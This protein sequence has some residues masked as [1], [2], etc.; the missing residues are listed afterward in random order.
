MHVT[1]SWAR[2]A[3]LLLAA[4]LVATGC[5]RHKLPSPPPAR[6]VVLIEENHAYSQIRGSSQAPWLNAIANQGTTMTQS[7][8]VTHPSEPNYLALFSGRTQGVSGDPCPPPGA[9]YSTPNLSTALGTVGRTFAGYSEDLPFTGS[10]RCSNGAYARKHNPVA[11]F[12]RVPANRNRPFSLFPTRTF[13]ALPTVSFVVPNLDHDM[14]DGSVAQGDAWAHAHLSG[15]VA[16]AQRH[17]SLLIVTFDEDNDSSGNHILT[18]FVGPMV[19]KGFSSQH[20]THYDLLRTI[21]SL[22]GARPVGNSLYGHAVVGIW[23]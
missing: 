21:E 6:T 19:K 22:Y 11:D 10:L 14:H 12:T 18:F 4:G 9:P 17:N 20:I 7:Y 3:T 23:K 1:R 13:A 15:Y 5:L 2:P 8:A 16:W